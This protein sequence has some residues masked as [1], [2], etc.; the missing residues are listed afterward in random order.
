MKYKSLN[1]TDKVGALM[2]HLQHLPFSLQLGRSVFR[3]GDAIALHLGEAPAGQ[4]RCRND[5]DKSG[6]CSGANAELAESDEVIRID[7]EQEHWRI[8]NVQIWLDHFAVVLCDDHVLAHSTGCLHARLC[9][10]MQVPRHMLAALQM[11]LVCLT[12]QQIEGNCTMLRKSVPT[13]AL[14][15]SCLCFTP[16]PQHS[17]LLQHSVKAIRDGQL[18][19]RE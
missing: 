12:S 4:S 9:N 2:Y 10:I 8:F 14:P 11:S 17:T 1:E 3:L 5:S 6:F 7:V 16:P 19:T 15:L 18:C 13:S